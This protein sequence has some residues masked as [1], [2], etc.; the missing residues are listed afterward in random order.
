M[1]SLSVISLMAIGLAQSPLD[2]APLTNGVVITSKFIAQLMEKAQASNP[3]FL[4]ADFRAKAA[5]ANVGSV[6][7]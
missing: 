1:K 2:G 7:E 3:S 5:T 4:A 6:R